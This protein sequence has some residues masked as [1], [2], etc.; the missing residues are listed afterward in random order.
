MHRL[1]LEMKLPDDPESQKMKKEADEYNG[2]IKALVGQMEELGN[3]GKIDE[4]QALLK[5]VDELKAK[6]L[7]IDRVGSGLL[8]R[9]NLVECVHLF[10]RS[11]TRCLHRCRVV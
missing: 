8:A 1:N 11:L 4:S 7:A 3:E 9:Y 6:K 10:R 5:L 2:Q